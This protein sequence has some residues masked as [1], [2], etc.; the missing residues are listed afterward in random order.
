MVALVFEP[1]FLGI[2]GHSAVV[3]DP[4]VGAG[5][6]VEQGGLAAVGIAHEG[7]P[8][9]MA[10]LLRELPHPP[11]EVLRIGAVRFAAAQ[12][13]GTGRIPGCLRLR[14]IVLS[15]LGLGL[16]LADDLYLAGLVPAER[17][18]VSYDL[19]FYGVPERGVEHHPD[20]LSLDEPHLG[21]SLAEG[22]VSAHF[23][24]NT[25]FTCF[26]I[27]KFHAANGL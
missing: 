19:V 16:A 10:A 12:S 25:S 20:L 7:D 22:A 23:D 6:N 13:G 2:D 4:L 18:L 26:Q 14:Y 17:Y 5:G 8:D 27:R 9:R 11:V 21:D 3:A 1:P 15:R 24:D